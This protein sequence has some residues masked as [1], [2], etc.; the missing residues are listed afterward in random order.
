MPDLHKKLLI[1]A[2]LGMLLGWF[3]FAFVFYPPHEHWNDDL[4]VGDVAT[5]LGAVATASAAVV[6]M[7]IAGKDRRRRDKEKYDDQ[8]MADFR[9]AVLMQP[10]FVTL[11]AVASEI[12]RLL[13]DA[14]K[15]GTRLYVATS[16]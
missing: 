8:D 15:S 9:S 3:I 5:W 2:F 12:R 16:L 13:G 11:N 7:L 1:A 14:E 10:T 6:A 4:K